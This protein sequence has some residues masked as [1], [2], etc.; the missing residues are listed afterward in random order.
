M[1]DQLNRREKFPCSFKNLFLKNFNLK[2][3]VKKERFQGY[4]CELGIAIFAR[5]VTLNFQILLNFF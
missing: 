4:R 1:Y 3:N 5:R 2:I